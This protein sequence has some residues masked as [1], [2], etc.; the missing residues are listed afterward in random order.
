MSRYHHLLSWFTTTVKLAIN[1]DKLNINKGIEGLLCL[2][3]NCASCNSIQKPSPSDI[4]SSDKKRKKE[5][6]EIIT[7]IMYILLTI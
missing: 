7:S 2:T 5:K 3:I 1:T 6:K 4:V